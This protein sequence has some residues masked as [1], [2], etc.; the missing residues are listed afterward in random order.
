MSEATRP[1][2]DQTTSGQA[3]V[4]TDDN[5]EGKTDETDKTTDSNDVLA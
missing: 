2:A 3:T 1:A 4:Y 5:E